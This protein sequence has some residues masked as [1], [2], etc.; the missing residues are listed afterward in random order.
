MSRNYDVIMLAYLFLGVAVI[1]MAL[2]MAL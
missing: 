1:V 2:V